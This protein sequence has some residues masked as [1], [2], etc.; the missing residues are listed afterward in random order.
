VRRGVVGSVG[1]TYLLRQSVGLSRAMELLLTGDLC[2]AQAALEMGLVSK[3]VPADLLLKE[4]RGFCKRLEQGAPLAQR[5]IK[6]VVR[7]GLEVDWRTL[8]EY[9]QML[10]D[11]LWESEDHLEGVRS[12]VERRAPRFRGR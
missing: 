4:A 9:A 5:A 1:G 10:S 8:D 3:V 2:D 7:K 6:R 12:F 11:P